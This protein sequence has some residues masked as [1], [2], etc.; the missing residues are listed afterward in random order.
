MCLSQ[1][2]LLR[3]CWWLRC[4]T[5]RRSLV[6]AA[7]LHAVQAWGLMNNR[8][9][10]ADRFPCWFQSV[11][12]IWYPSGPLKNIWVKCSHFSSNHKFFQVNIIMVKVNILTCLYS[13]LSGHVMLSVARRQTG[14]LTEQSMLFSKDAGIPTAFYLR[15]Q[16]KALAVLCP[17]GI[18]LQ[19]M[20][21]A[22]ASRNVCSG[23]CSFS[24]AS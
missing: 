16:L 23:M 5:Y 17:L 11:I 13:T 9:G 7:G 24:Q 8:E 2:S 14:C 4:Y 21:D 22:C 19:M 20:V 15:A 12:D 6:N 10:L 18:Y 3:G 1:M